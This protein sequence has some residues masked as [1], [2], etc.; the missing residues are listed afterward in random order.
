VAFFELGGLTMLA[1]AVLR[2]YRLIPVGDLAPAGDMPASLG[3]AGPDGFALSQMRGLAELV[4]ATTARIFETAL[5]L[6]APA[7]VA[8]CLVTLA[9]SFIARAVP[10]LGGLVASP[11]VRAWLGLG[12]IVLG[13][14]VFE[15]TRADG[16]SGAMS[17]L[18]GLLR[19]AIELW[20]AR[21]P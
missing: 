17:Q 1:E 14:G 7:I 10:G 19:S 16:W 13:L 2:S 3:R 18:P 12:V 8:A 9:W 4:V 21:R 15:L 5:V 11:Q 20:R 6:A